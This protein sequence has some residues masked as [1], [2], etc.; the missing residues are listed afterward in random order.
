MDPITFEVIRSAL[1]AVADE[2]KVILTRSARSPLLQEAG[3]LSCALTDS[4]GRLVAQGDDMPIHLGVMAFTVK[5]LLRRVDPATMKPGDFYLTNALD[6]GGNHLPDMKG[7]AP[8][9]VDGHLV[10]VAETLAHW[11]DVGGMIP[12]SY[13]A[14]ATEIYQE[15]LQIPPVKV[16]EGGKVRHEVVDLILANVR[17]REQRFGD[18]MAQYAATQY[19]DRR[20]RALV[21][22]YGRP[23]MLGAMEESFNYSERR[24]RHAISSIPDGVYSAEDFMD[25]DGVGRRAVRIVVKVTVA[26]GEITYD[27]TGTDPQAAGPINTTYFITCSAAYCATRNLTDPSIPANE[28][29]YR[30]IRVIAPEGTVLNARHPAPVVAGNH[31]TS[32]RVIDVIVLALAPAIPSQVTA[33][34]FGS[35]FVSILSGRDRRR[36]SPFTFYEIGPGGYGARPH[37]DGTNGTR[38]RIGN[39]KNTPAEVVEK[40]YPVRVVEYGVIPDSG[41]AGKFRGGLGVRRAYRVL[42]PATASIM[43]ERC[44]FRPYGLFGGEAGRAGRVQI[45]AAAGHVRRALRGK[46][47]AELKA[48]EVLVVESAG[49]GGYGRPEERSPAALEADRLDGYVTADPRDAADPGAN[50]KTANP[51]GK[52]R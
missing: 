20:V 26:G 42:E 3:D 50:S 15:G 44:R 19:A 14:R 30:P 51:R 52:K 32:E 21:E 18:L 37:R 9:F 27:F 31:E 7:I 13:S 39:T 45:L 1:Y 29:C 23:T 5:E 38:A 36:A 49:G 17:G 16:I 4:Q 28:G 35:A 6:V 46:D 41:G 43:G 10:A 2:M 25:D 33:A 47:V 11:A 48:G 8:I 40:A 22:A 24:M 34:C 12:G